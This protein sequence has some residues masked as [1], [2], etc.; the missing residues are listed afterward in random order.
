MKQDKS[1]ATLWCCA[2]VRNIKIILA[3]IMDATLRVFYVWCCS[4][5]DD[6]YRKLVR[7]YDWPAEKC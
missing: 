3:P 7:P 4:K 2:F 1:N 5:L 6:P